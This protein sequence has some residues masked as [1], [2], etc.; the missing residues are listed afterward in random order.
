H[1]VDAGAKGSERPGPISFMGDKCGCT[2]TPYPRGH[3]DSRPELHSTSAE[4]QMQCQTLGRG[5]ACCKPEFRLD[6]NIV[7][8]SDA[9]CRECGIGHASELLYGVQVAAGLSSGVLA[10]PFPR[11]LMSLPTAT[12]DRLMR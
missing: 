8:R 12:Q 10:L 3:S 5:Q 6:R 7:R 11:S 9:V 2:A 4:S 1:H